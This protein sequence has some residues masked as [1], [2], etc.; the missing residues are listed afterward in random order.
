M[1]IDTNKIMNTKTMKTRMICCLLMAVTFQTVNAQLT[2]E[3]SN[4]Y[5]KADLI[6]IK[7]TKKMTANPRNGEATL[8]FNGREVKVK[9]G[10]EVSLSH[11]FDKD[12]VSYIM[13]VNDEEMVLRYAYYLSDNFEFSYDYSEEGKDSTGSWINLNKDMMVNG[14]KKDDGTN[15]RIISLTK[16][17][18]VIGFKGNKATVELTA[19][20]LDK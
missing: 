3:A 20:P 9:A 7:W 12:S 15:L 8:D 19:E 2:E 11:I 1:R 17:K 4:M 10:D 13:K 5:S 6:G 18:L 14:K 16:E